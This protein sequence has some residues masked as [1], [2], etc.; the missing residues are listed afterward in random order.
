MSSR[1]S[2]AF[3]LAALV[4]VSACGSS[5]SSAPSPTLM[6]PSTP[7]GLPSIN[8]SP[9]PTYD[10][11]PKDPTVAQCRRDVEAA[12]QATQLFKQSVGYYAPDLKTLVQAHLLT[13]VSKNVHYG[14]DAPN[15]E[16]V[17]IGN[18]PGC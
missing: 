2:Y 17:V 6:A 18:I 5:S 16:P 8:N 13:S 3:G 9:Y 14:Y 11:S 15:V 10:P 12:Q 1:I 7:D 4:A